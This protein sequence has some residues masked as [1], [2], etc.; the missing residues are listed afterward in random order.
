MPLTRQEEFGCFSDATVR[1]PEMMNWHRRERGGLE[2]GQRSGPHFQASAILVTP[3]FSLTSWVPLIGTP[4]RLRE[5][6]ELILNKLMNAPLGR[7]V[8]WDN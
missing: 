1:D 8:N 7:A 5:K 3:E 6:N 4:A 2:R